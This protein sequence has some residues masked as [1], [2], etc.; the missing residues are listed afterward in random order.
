MVWGTFVVVSYL[1]ICTWY[2]HSYIEWSIRDSLFFVIY[3]ITTVGFGT[4]H[5]GTATDNKFIPRD[6]STLLF[7]SF[8]TL[9]GIAFWFLFLQLATTYVI[10]T[11]LTMTSQ[12]DDKAYIAKRGLEALESYSNSANSVIQ[13][14]HGAN[15][16]NNTSSFWGGASF[17]TKADLQ[18]YFRSYTGEKSDS[19]LYKMKFFI[20]RKVIDKVKDY[21]DRTNLQPLI[22]FL[23]AF[24]S[25]IGFL[26]ITIMILEKWP[27]IKSLY[28]SVMYVDIKT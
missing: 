16:G 25:S 15:N 18:K 8:S 2:F 22:I 1:T 9:L 27:F 3:T 19:I 17:A 26:A 28:F 14:T 21:I 7:I 13:G 5:Y 6:R 12:D 20:R 23:T 24:C 4:P 10:Q 11:R